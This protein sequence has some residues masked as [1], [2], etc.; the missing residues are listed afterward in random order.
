MKLFANKNEV[1]RLDAR[2]DTQMASTGAPH[3]LDVLL[4]LAWHLRQRDT[5][6]A[7]ALQ[8]GVQKKRGKA[9]PGCRGWASGGGVLA[10][11]QAQV[12]WFRGL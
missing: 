2:L 4:P 3:T 9:G 10:G 7:V 5:G 1:E 8:G 12:Q 6:R 11:G